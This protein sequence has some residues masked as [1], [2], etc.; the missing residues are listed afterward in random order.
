MIC[1]IG[2]IS[3][4]KSKNYRILF[5]LIMSILYFY[6][7]VSWLGNT[8]NYVPCLMFISFF[9]AFGVDKIQKIIEVAKN[10]Q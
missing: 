3:M 5:F 8:R 6:V 4:V 1:L 10:K 9:F 2:F 7:P